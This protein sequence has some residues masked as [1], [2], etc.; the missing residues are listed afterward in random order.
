M[1]PFS[2]VKNHHISSGGIWT[3]RL[4]D[5]R[6][7]RRAK[8]VLDVLVFSVCIPEFICIPILL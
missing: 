1:F 3:V 4:R 5:G 7:L 2:C 8:N 6:K